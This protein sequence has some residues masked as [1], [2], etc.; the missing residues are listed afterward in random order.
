MFDTPNIEYKLKKYPCM[1]CL[2]RASCNHY[3]ECELP[4]KNR[5]EC[6]RLIQLEMCPDCGDKNI[7]RTDHFTYKCL[8]CNH[9]FYEE[10]GQLMR[11]I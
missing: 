9:M 5:K 2:V 10:V 11:R 8:S 4:T 6:Y 3:L 7:C 1:V